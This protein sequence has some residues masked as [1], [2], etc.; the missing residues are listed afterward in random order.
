MKRSFVIFALC[1][2]L[3]GPALADCL[4]SGARYV[5]LDNGTVSDQ[6]TGLMWQRCLKGR[7]GTDCTDG[8]SSVEDEDKLR[9]IRLVRDTK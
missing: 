9:P 8:T 6:T 5:I 2:G 3:S 4:V 1:A 7:S